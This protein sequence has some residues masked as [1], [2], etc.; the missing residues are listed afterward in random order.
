MQGNRG[1]YS[2][3]ANFYVRRVLQSRNG[4]PISLAV[5]HVEVGR[6]A[7]LQVE[8]IG[9]PLHVVTRFEFGHGE[10]LEERF[11]DVYHGGRTFTRCDAQWRSFS[12]LLDRVCQLKWSRRVPAVIPKS[13]FHPYDL[14]NSCCDMNRTATCCTASSFHL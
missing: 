12:L 11:V 14:V 9:M 5:I 8:A 7:G 6:R 13:V 3:F 1:D 10:G 4:I 2:T